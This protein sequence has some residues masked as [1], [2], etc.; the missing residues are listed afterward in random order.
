MELDARSSQ[1]LRELLTNP[2]IK[3]KDLEHKYSL[4]RRQV[5]Y[6]LSKINDWLK[7]NYLPEIKRSRTGQFLIGKVLFT[8]LSMD[9]ERNTKGNYNLSAEERANLIILMMLSKNEELSLFHFTHALGVSKNT[10]LRDLK[11]A[12]DAISPLHLEIKYSRMHGYY[13][14]GNEFNQRQALIDIVH[15]TLETYGGENWLRE[16]AGAAPS[17]PKS[18]PFAAKSKRWKAS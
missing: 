3:N 15:K 2:G 5:E 6:S 7:A 1:L 8:A 18:P 12:Q 16:L 9:R 14:E 11:N 17:H 13:I 10:I 4:S